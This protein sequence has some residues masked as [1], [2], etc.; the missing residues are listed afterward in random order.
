VEKADFL[1]YVLIALILVIP[2]SQFYRRYKKYEFSTRDEVIAAVAAIASTIFQLNSL[3]PY[4]F[5]DKARSDLRS[6]LTDSGI[7]ALFIGYAYA[8]SGAIKTI[9]KLLPPSEKL[10]EQ[11]EQLISRML[12]KGISQEVIAY[13]S[14]VSIQKI[15][16]YVN[17]NSFES[18][19][20]IDSDE[21]DSTTPSQMISESLP[22]VT[23]E[24]EK[25]S[26]D[27]I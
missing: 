1:L 21:I 25:D 13:V 22:I 17:N 5:Q 26:K 15:Q 9:K 10:D 18:N 23:K 14:Q 2:Y 8:F 16:V 6:I 3:L 4:F 27:S 12:E 19:A 7:A 11:T 20:Q 24:K